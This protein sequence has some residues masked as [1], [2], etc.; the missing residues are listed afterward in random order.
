MRNRNIIPMILMAALMISCCSES[1]YEITI[2]GIETRALVLDG[3]TNVI[4]FDKLNSIDKN[5]FII[6]IDI[7]EQEKI[8]S[9]EF[10]NHKNEDTEVLNAAVIP[11]EDQLLIYK[12]NIDS[13]K[14]EIFDV[15]N[16]NERI[17][18]TNQLV[19][20]DTQTSVSQYVSQQSQG[21]G[22][23]L[24]QFSDTSNIP[25]RIEYTIEATLDDGSKIKAMNG[26]INFN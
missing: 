16:N 13:I 22:D 2:I 18:I 1:T 24:V 3:G 5:D 17:D 19:I 11:C 14:V 23:F 25:G 7:I 21:I 20:L 9:S 8:V 4:E 26:V 12:N 6:E 15:D 10:I